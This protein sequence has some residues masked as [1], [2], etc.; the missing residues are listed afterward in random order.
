MSDDDLARLHAAAP[1]LAAWAG[2]MAEPDRRDFVIPGHKQDPTLLG[3]VVHGDLPLFGGLAPVAEAA[4]LLERA[5]AEAAALWGVDWCRFSVAGST[6][7]NL[8]TALAVG[9]PG[10]TVVVSRTLHRSLMSGLVLAGLVPVWVHPRPLPGTGLP[11]EV[12]V[13]DVAEALARHPHAVAVFVGDPSYVGTRSDVAALARLCHAHV[14]APGPHGG[15][16]GGGSGAGVGVPLVV[17]AAWAAHHGF[18]PALPP[19][20]VAAG[21]DALVTSAHKLLPALN[22]GALVLARTRAAGGLLDAHRLGTAFDTA[23]TTSPSGAVLASVDAARALLATRGPEL[24]RR[25]LQVTARVREVL[26]AVPGAV[27]LEDDPAG[28]GV[29]VDPTKVVVHLAGTGADGREV[30]RRVLARGLSLELAERDLLVPVVSLADGPR[31][32][33]RLAV[34]LAAAIGACRGRPRPVSPAAAWSVRPQQVVPP[35]E[36]F[37]AG[38]ESVPAGRAA[39]RVCAELVAPYPPGVPV[40]APGE[41]VTA[42]ALAALTQ[43]RDHGA[44]IAYAADPTLATVRVVA[45]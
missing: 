35:R 16:A 4:A 29:R 5:E 25:H 18:H 32:A 21:A 6:H 34:E 31:H 13:A 38:H 41:L 11:G 17:D 12:P 36:A 9:R 40:L 20:A 42:E 7:G 43:A 28:D 1:L 3:P 27:L 24:L 14:R 22:Q 8:A 45:P 44:R 30:A 39:G 26:R 23:H 37:F 10:D 15:G 19:H 2:R 33:E